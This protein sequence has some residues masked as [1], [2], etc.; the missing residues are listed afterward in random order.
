MRAIPAVFD[1]LR[2]HRE[3][4][5]DLALR[6]MLQGSAEFG[7]EEGL[8]RMQTDLDDAVNL[9]RPNPLNLQARRDRRRRILQRRKL[10]R[11]QAKMERDKRNEIKGM[12]VARVNP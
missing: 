4:R 5:R 3:G 11:M 2:L 6:P 9:F 7:S 12:P 10:R 1:A 8:A